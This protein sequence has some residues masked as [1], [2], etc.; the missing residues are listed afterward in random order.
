MSRSVKTVQRGIILKRFPYTISGR[1]FNI[2]LKDHKD[3]STAL[4]LDQVA[5]ALH[6]NSHSAQHRPQTAFEV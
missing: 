3:K 2:F 5:K 6:N 1:V 4:G